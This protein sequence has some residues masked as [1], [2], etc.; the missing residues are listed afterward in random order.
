MLALLSH[1]GCNPRLATSREPPHESVMRFHC[2]GW[3]AML[4][5]VPRV[6]VNIVPL[7]KSLFVRFRCS[8]EQ[9]PKQDKKEILHGDER[10]KHDRAPDNPCG[11][12]I[13]DEDERDT[14]K[15][16][17]CCGDA[18]GNQP[19]AYLVHGPS[20]GELVLLAFSIVPFPNLINPW[21]A[22]KVDVWTS[23]LRQGCG[24]RRAG[25]WGGFFSR[26]P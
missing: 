7:T 11:T 12:A 20:F 2:I 13:Q 16:Q 24:A 5:V 9:P 4:A 3:F 15:E 1:N 26:R 8:S 17:Q 19:Q 21:H 6:L 10:R 18:E 14:E 25:R 22:T 23:I